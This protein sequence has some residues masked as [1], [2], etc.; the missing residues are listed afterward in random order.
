[1]QERAQGHHQHAEMVHG[2]KHF[3][4]THYMHR[5][6][7]WAHLT[8]SHEHEHNHTQV[9]HVH[10]PHQDEETEHRREAHIHD[11][12]RPASSPG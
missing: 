6:E 1:M 4:V 2:H 9:D 8:A 11:H 3:H 12:A 7:N 10:I 5:G